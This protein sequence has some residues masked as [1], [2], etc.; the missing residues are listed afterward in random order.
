MSSYST[1]SRRIHPESLRVDGAA[2]PGWMTGAEHTP[3]VGDQVYCTEGMGQVVRVLG[4]TQNGSRLLELKL[5]DGR[6]E[7]FFAAASNVLVAPAEAP[8]L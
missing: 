4:R 3:A 6:R 1:T 5:A 2:H 7:S 8:V